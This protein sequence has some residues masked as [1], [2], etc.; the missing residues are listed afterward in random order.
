MQFGQVFAGTMGNVS[1][2]ALKSAFKQY[3]DRDDEG[4]CQGMFFSNS[5]TSSDQEQPQHRAAPSLA[6]ILKHIGGWFELLE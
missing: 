2:A 3:R 6:M 4:Y 5:S 1:L